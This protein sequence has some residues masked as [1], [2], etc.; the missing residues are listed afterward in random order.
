MALLA[1][2]LF[3]A[4]ALSGLAGLAA[5]AIP[6]PKPAWT[7]FGFEVVVTVSAI[8]GFVYVRTPNPSAPAMGLAWLAGCIA[9]ASALGFL[10]A[11]QLGG[12]STLPF[13]AGRVLLAAG[14]GGIA[15]VAA[16]GSDRRR[17]ATLFKGVAAGIPVVA[18]LGLLVLPFGQRLLAKVGTGGTLSFVIGTL[19]FLVLTALAAASVHLIVRS[20]QSQG[21]SP[22]PSEPSKTA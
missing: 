11:Q 5:A 2:G 9:A 7:L 8:L 12:V 18:S 6:M 16:L 14:I 20:F 10:S 17:W 1:S 13:A 15:I 21:F 19:A 22:N 4:I 3:V